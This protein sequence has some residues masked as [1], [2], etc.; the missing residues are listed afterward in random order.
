MPYQL[1]E[2]EV[3]RS[4]RIYA[5]NAGCVLLKIQG[6]RGWP[7]RLLIAPDGRHMFIEFKKRGADLRPL[8]EEI[9]CKL[10]KMGHKAEMVDSVEQFMTCLDSLLNLGFPRP[11]KS[12]E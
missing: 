2:S 3:E 5:R 4:C 10:R 12:E 8:Q 1:S 7:D 11:T 9:Q 6:V